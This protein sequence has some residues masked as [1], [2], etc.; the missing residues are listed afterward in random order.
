MGRQTEAPN[1]LDLSKEAANRPNKVGEQEAE[2][3]KQRNKNF[4]DSVKRRLS[5]YSYGTRLSFSSLEDDTADELEFKPDVLAEISLQASP[6]PESPPKV[7]H[8]KPSP[9][10]NSPIEQP[11]QRSDAPRKSL[12]ESLTS[13]RSSKKRSFSEFEASH[14][15]QKLDMDAR[16]VIQ[17]QSRKKRS[18]PN[19]GPGTSTHINLFLT[20]ANP[21]SGANSD[22]QVF[23]PRDLWRLNP[24]GFSDTQ[25]IKTD[26]F[27]L[28]IIQLAPAYTVNIKTGS[29]TITAT[30]LS[31]QTYS[32]E[33]T[34]ESKKLQLSQWE[35]FLV[36]PYCECSITNQGSSTK[37]KLQL[38]I[39]KP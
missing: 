28:T 23:F 8:K 25:L 20:Y 24:E 19:L 26:N 5:R 10:V 33:V 4:K 14:Q 11:K 16:T 13:S 3:S 30:V 9:I 12:I 39:T 36:L 35:T 1:S 2:E 29:E 15:A 17:T 32:V 18:R 22:E 34:I 31:A 6:V 37:A 27:E 21:D 38:F 7:Q